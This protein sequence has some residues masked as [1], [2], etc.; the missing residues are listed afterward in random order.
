MLLFMGIIAHDSIKRKNPNSV[1]F[2]SKLLSQK[3]FKYHAIILL[4]QLVHQTH[5]GDEQLDED[6]TFTLYPTYTPR[7]S[8]ILDT[9]HIL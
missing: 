1:V 5:T 2:R 9:L 8:S 7:T 6:M 3:A 4:R